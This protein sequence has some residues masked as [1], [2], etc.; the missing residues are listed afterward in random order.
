MTA[1]QPRPRIV[2]GAF[3]SWL[4]AAVLLVLG[5]GVGP[6][7]LVSFDTLRRTTPT[8]VSDVQLQKWLMLYRGAW[9][10][11]LLIGLAIA[12]LAGRVR[13][14]D[15]RSRRAAVAL[16]LVAVVLLAA[17]GFAHVVTLYALVSII[18]LIIA[19]GLITRPAAS[20]WFDAVDPSGAG[21]G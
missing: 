5:G 12:Y 1:A 14:G 20:A 16:S 11:C 3:W 4:V 15:N 10:L 13:R 7:L 19:A 9:L 8:T 2:D 6:L 18:P 17:G 21:H